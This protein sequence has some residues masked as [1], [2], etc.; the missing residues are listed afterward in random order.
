MVD[1]VDSAVELLI[2]QDGCGSVEQ[3][4]VTLTIGL[5]DAASTRIT[6]N[7]R[8]QIVPEGTTIATLL[9]RLGLQTKFHAVEWNGRVVR[10]AD[11]QTVV[12]SAGDQVEIVT[13]VGGG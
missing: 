8:E 10:R 7:D 12:L 13:L 1:L 4:V 6:V 2:L 9:E 11:H 3:E 5:S